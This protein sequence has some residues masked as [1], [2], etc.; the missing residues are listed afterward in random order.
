MA[1]DVVVTPAGLNRWFLHDRL[2]RTVGTISKSDDRFRIEPDGQALTGI[3]F[4]PFKSL[5]LAMSE[6]E[7]HT[8]GTCQLATGK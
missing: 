5:D 7:R 3:S 6:I 4:G 8:K 1:I 2:A